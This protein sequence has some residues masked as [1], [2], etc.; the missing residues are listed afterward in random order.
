ML[1]VVFTTVLLLLQIDILNKKPNSMKLAVLFF[2]S[3]FLCFSCIETEKATAPNK[4]EA[5]S[6]K[7]VSKK[8][9]SLITPGGATIKSRFK[10]PEG[11]QRVATRPNSF[12]AYLQNLP[13]KPHGA[14]VHYYNGAEKSNNGVYLAVVDMDLVKGDL[15]QCADAIMRLRGEYL[16]EQK[17][18]D[19]I[20]FNFTNG[21]E[22][23]Y[24][25]WKEGYRI[26]VDGNKV[27]WYKSKAPS[28][29][30]SEFKK[31]LRMI[32][33]YA[34]TLSLAKELKPKSIK[35]IEIG[36]VFIQGG[37]P[38]HAVIVVDMAI[39]ARRGERRFLLA[40]SYMP[41]QETQILMNPV[42]SSTNPW[43]SNLAADQIRTPEWI[44]SIE[45]LKRF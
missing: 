23:P 44:F 18:Y 16:F 40:Q 9:D 5:I 14:K 11:F 45:D 28:S 20:K 13:L 7:K 1:S 17:Q 4:I 8:N 3:L 15:Q 37:S 32:F 38:G 27:S 42:N 10:A 35:D 36:D 12:A 43:Y 30:Y 19:Q 41:A 25:K 21:F 26:K 31:Y 2:L 34:G 33:I 22:A 6:A 39:N 29:S 24:K